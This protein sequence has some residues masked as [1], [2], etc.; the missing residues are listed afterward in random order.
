MRLSILSAL[1]LSFGL[2]PLSF[3]NDTTVTQSEIELKVPYTFGEHKLIAKE[4]KGNI[5]WSADKDAILEAEFK[6]SVFDLKA[7]DKTLMCHL[8]SSIALNYETSVF[9]KEHVCENDKL[10]SEGANA[11][12]Y[13]DITA[14][15]VAPYKLG[16]KTAKIAWSIHGVTKEQTVPLEYTYDETSKRFT[17]QGT[18]SMRRSDFKIKVKKFLFIDAS[19]KLPVSVKISGEVR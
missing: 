10:P 8:Q 4:L 15:L 6:L 18:W 14:R 1:V 16:D 5:V 7:D 12:V 17:V 19:D 3:A 13:P 9:P 2:T 11:P